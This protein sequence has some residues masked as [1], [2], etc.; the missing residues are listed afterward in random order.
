MINFR[1]IF[2]IAVICLQPLIIGGFWSWYHINTPMGNLLTGDAFGMLLCYGRLSGLLAVFLVL[3][4]I[5][6]ISRAKWIESLFGHDRLAH[7][8]G[9]I[10]FSILVLLII[11]PIFLTIGQSIQTETTYLEQF[12]DFCKNWEDVFAALI[13]LVIIFVVIITSIFVRLKKLNYEVWYYIHLSLYVAIA[14]AFAH[15]I[16]VGSDINGSEIFKYYWYFFYAFVFLNLIFYRFL[17][18]ILNFWKHRFQIS[19]VKSETP[20]VTSVY[21]DGQNMADFL[22]KPGQFLFLRFIAK[23]FIWE[24]HPFSVSGRM[25]DGKVRVSIKALGNFTRK[26]PNLI[27][28]TS[29]IIDGPHGIFTSDICKSSKLLL[30]AGGIGITP[31]RSIA[32]DMIINQTDTIL[33]YSNRNSKSIAFKDEL[34]KL[35]EES[36]GKLK[37]IY[38]VSDDPE[39]TGEK[40]KLDKEKLNRFVPDL[41]EREVYLC[42][43]SPM[44][45]S[46]IKML[47]EF[48]V[49]RSRIHFEKFSL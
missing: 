47:K 33:L 24:K 44:M 11:H 3:L 12:I 30:I 34:D 46:T 21:I 18:P 4:Q 48:G 20:D 6:L 37:V 17:Q 26:I 19:S 25:E 9:I 32:E 5:L 29:V 1:K 40:G 49:K 43:P 2:L 15:Q 31:I 39:W 42:G 38:L 7:A 27:P 45:K 13:S 22:T 8:H 36:M 35:H 23:G 16:E 10:G 14:L 28:G 41:I